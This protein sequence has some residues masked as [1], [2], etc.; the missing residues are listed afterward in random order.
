MSET[1]DGLSTSTA[2]RSKAPDWS[3]IS[4]KRDM[5]VGFTPLRCTASRY[6]TSIARAPLDPSGR[7]S[8][9]TASKQRRLFE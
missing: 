3:W 9:K 7:V 6:L 5:G 1:C 4:T 8:T 2:P